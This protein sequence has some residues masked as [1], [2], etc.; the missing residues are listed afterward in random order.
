[1]LSDAIIRLTGNRKWGRRVS[2]M[3]GQAGAGLALLSTIWVQDPIA[4]GVLLGTAFF[5]NDLGMGPA[6]AACSDVGERF[7]GTVGGKMNM[8]GNI[9]GGLGML[10]AGHL[11]YTGQVTAVFIVFACSYGLGVLCWLG[12]DATRP[13]AIGPM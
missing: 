9:A 2:G 3:F 8:V 12:L 5:C 13:A 10:V 6:W 11:L 1:V 4:L 7:A